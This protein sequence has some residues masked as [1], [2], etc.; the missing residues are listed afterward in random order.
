MEETARPI[1]YVVKGLCV[2]VCVCVCVCTYRLLVSVQDVFLGEESHAVHQ[3]YFTI[4]L[5]GT[6]IDA[7]TLARAHTH[8]HT[9]TH[10]RT[11]THTHTHTHT[12]KAREHTR[13]DRDKVWR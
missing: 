3:A 8:T 13:T 4:A 6:N 10:T 11:H 1:W 2:C 5:L 12:L 7:A 9:H